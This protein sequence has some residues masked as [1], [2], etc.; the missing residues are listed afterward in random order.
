VE[1]GEV[2]T[3]DLPWCYLLVGSIIGKFRQLERFGFHT[4]FVIQVQDGLITVSGDGI[5]ALPGC[6]GRIQQIAEEIQEDLREIEKISGASMELAIRRPSRS[7]IRCPQR[8]HKRKVSP[9]VGLFY[10][11]AFWPGRD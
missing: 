8:R 3:D 1:S 11:L 9:M 7:A 10:F 4:Q 5:S 2:D 6:T